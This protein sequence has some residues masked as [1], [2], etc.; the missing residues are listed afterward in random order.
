MLVR[1]ELDAIGRQV[2][3][4]YELYQAAARL[5]WVAEASPIPEWFQ[6]FFR[7][8]TLAHTIRVWHPI[9]VPGPLQTPA[10]AR[11]QPCNQ[12]TPAPTV[13]INSIPNGS[14]F[15]PSPSHTSPRPGGH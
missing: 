7:A 8:H 2:P 10:S 13:R 15:L 1:C 6:D 11:T 4:D 5:A 9:I 3:S 14:W 12:V